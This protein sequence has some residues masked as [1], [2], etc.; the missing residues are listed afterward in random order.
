MDALRVTGLVKSFGSYK[1]INGL[2]LAVPEH[3]VFGFI[4]PNG[5]GKTTTMKMV[6]GLMKPDSGSIC[7]CGEPVAYGRTRTNRLIGYLPDVPEF[8]GFMNAR[9]YLK[10]CGEITGMSAGLIG[11]RGGALLAMVGL[12][13]VKKRISTYS[14]GM[15]QRLG[16]AQAL[17]NEP[18]LL[19]CDEPTSALDPIGR[20]EILDILRAAAA[21]T[22]VLFSTH[23]LSDVERICDE[24]AVLSGG[25]IA[26][27]GT[28]ASI[29]AAHKQ[30]MLQ[31]ECVSRADLDTFCLS[32]RLLPFMADAQASGATVTFRAVDISAV[33]RAA[34]AAF[35]EQGVLPVRMELPEPTLET[36]FMEAVR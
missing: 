18:R 25:R 17:L 14:R 3:S 6:L 35:A 26:L 30:D 19:L 1:V 8:Y 4:G 9:E 20:K 5:A 28:L 24:I 7:V 32:Q 23:I 12:E 15:K 29:R 22:T 27:S 16:I 31:V 11:M 33:Q 34:L 21:H 13:G 2:D 10:L 36:L